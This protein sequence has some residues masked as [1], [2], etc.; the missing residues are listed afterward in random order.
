MEFGFNQ[1]QIDFVRFESQNAFDRER[2]LQRI[3][4]LSGLTDSVPA[5]QSRDGEPETWWTQLNSTH[6]S[7]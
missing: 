1:Q 4:K 7:G 3:I 2:L 5:S 6:D